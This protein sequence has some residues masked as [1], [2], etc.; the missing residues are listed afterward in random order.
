MN[1]S[2][3]GGAHVLV[4]NDHVQNRELTQTFLEH[5]G[6]RVSTAEQGDAAVRAFAQ[7][8]ADLVLLDVMLP[9]TDGFT[10]YQR[11]RQL[12]SGD[13]A[14][15]VF[16]TSDDDPGTQRRAL[17]S[18]AD[19]LL[20]KPLQRSE[21]LLRVQSVLRSKHLHGEQ[22]R[23]S[24]LI[25]LQR[26]ELM[27]L[28]RQREENIALLV[29]DMKNPLAGVLSNAEFMVTSG[30]LDTD[31]SECANDILHASRRLHR[32]VMSL[33]D[34]SQSEH[35]MLRPA[36]VSFEL[37]ELVMSVRSQCAAKLRDKSLTLTVVLPPEPIPIEA[38]RDMLM[39]LLSN[40]L[41]NA[42][43]HAPANTSVGLE[44]HAD[45]DAIELRVSD[46]GPSIPE[47]ERGEIF[48]SY[49]QLEDRAA[50]LRARRGLGLSSSRAVVEAHGGRIWVEDCAREGATF[51][52]RLPRRRKTTG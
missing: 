30:G 39:R 13:Q 45:D 48:D 35:G 5:A 43:R 24:E 20:M 41:D 8:P 28:Q 49:V 12:P 15:I 11:L 36:S 38:D 14:A 42:M 29:H 22:E 19:D 4:V 25:R 46:A 21:L 18:G 7:T 27:R 31:Q 9:D 44:V 3:L 16:V 26:D 34:V 37:T 40:L 52:V 6:Y 1:S 51:C 33:L 17:E 2:S 50:R 10:T 47:P 32:M 23:A